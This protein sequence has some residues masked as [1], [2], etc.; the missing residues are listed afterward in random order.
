MMTN[1]SSV[2]TEV[3]Q[4]YVKFTAPFVKIRR[5]TKAKLVCVSVVD[6]DAL[7][8]DFIEYDSLFYND[9]LQPRHMSMDFLSGKLLHLIFL[10]NKLIPFA[11]VRPHT[12]SREKFYRSLLGKNVDV[13][14]VK[15]KP[16]SA[17]QNSEKTHHAVKCL[18]LGENN[19]CQCPH[20]TADTC[21]N[22]S[23]ACNGYLE[24]NPT[25][26]LAIKELY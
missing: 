24:D 7:H 23:S 4:P 8:P 6:S 12:P 2:S 22:D 5:Q 26:R 25:N 14:I 11:T 15:F 9:R 19:F 3:D 17:N 10:G 20:I 18:F 21:N 16:A 1:S 13:K